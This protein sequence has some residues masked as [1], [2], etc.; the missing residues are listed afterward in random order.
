MALP[1]IN[2]WLVIRA[3]LRQLADAFPEQFD[4][5]VLIG[6]G[7]CWFYRT[8]LEKW[9]DPDFPMPPLSPAEEA[10]WLSKD[11]DFMGATVAEAEKLLGA[12]FKTETHTI[13]FHGL[14]VDFLEQGVWLT[15][16]E[17]VRNAREI[18]TPEIVFR[19]IDAAH[20]FAEKLAVLRQKE[21][22]QD[23]LHIKVLEL[24]LKCEFCREVETLESLDARDWV[25]R[26]R[27]VKTADHDFF[28]RDPLFA[29]RLRRGISQLNQKEYA[30]IVHWAK[31][32]LPA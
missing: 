21:R 16:A 3:A 19:V 17:A 13:S 31:H 7:A 30:R 9:N 15:T 29:Q 27:V 26:A 28:V 1:K 23:R 4:D 11:I 18:R 24:F 10:V 8:M 22:P 20:V 25:E 2:D 5:W 32:H 12:P 14:E 6:G